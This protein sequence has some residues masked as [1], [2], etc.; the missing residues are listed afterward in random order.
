M[1]AIITRAFVGFRHAA[2]LAVGGLEGG[3]TGV[4]CATVTSTLAKDQGG[5]SLAWS[6]FV[7]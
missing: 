3:E 1:T 4:M 7:S 5:L 6:K 2:G